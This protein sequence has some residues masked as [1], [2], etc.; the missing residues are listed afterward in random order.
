M[1]RLVR[2]LRLAVLEKVEHPRPVP[3]RLIPRGPAR[4]WRYRAWVRTLPS[5]VSG[6]WP[7]EAAHT[8]SDGG[9]GMKSSDYSCV[10]LTFE[11][12]REYHRIGRRAFE[13][14]HQIS[15]ASLVRD[16]NRVWFEFAREVQ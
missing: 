13:R 8:G 7:C 16:L 1:T 14:K 6:R 9:M 4:D 3:R 5:A 2:Y 15:M 12:H 10:P 11:E